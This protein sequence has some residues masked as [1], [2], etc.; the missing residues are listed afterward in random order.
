GGGTWI[1]CNPWG[2]AAGVSDSPE[3][4][5]A[6]LRSL[7]LGDADEALCDLYVHEGMRVVDELDRCTG[8]TWQ[9]LAGV[10]DYHAELPGGKDAGRSLEIRPVRLPADVLARV[11]TDP[12]GTPPVTILEEAAGAMAPDE[13]EL[14]SRDGLVMR[15]R[16]LIAALLA[17]LLELG[18]QAVSGARAQRLLG[19]SDGIVGVEADGREFRGQVVLASG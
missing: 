15:G 10:S 17:T 11:R 8:L 14:R 13:L 1:P 5:V 7:G 16:G 19:S 2:A 4:A 3:E 18:G 12:H 9:H 6:Y